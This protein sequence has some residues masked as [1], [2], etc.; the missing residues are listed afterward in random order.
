M[1]EF[2]EEDTLKLFEK[3]IIINFIHHDQDNQVLDEFFD[4]LE[5]FSHFD[6]QGQKDY[7]HPQVF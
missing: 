7:N 2:L 3:F 4:Q 6:N 5:H 1:K